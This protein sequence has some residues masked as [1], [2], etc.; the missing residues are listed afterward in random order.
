MESMHRKPHVPL[1]PIQ[2]RR[3]LLTCLGLVLATFLWL[4][5]AP[6][7][8]IYS[9]IHQRTEISN[10]QTENA[11]IREENKTL[12]KEIHQIQDDPH[13]L[14]KVARD[15]YGLLKENEMIFDF[16]PQKKEKKK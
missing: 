12:E 11:E 3:L 5:F 8:G 2:K 1:S 7:M 13:F 9:V 4:V 10:I 14:E 15:K 16:S 6:H